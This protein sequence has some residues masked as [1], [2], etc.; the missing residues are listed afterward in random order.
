M[1]KGIA[2]AHS[3][4][5]IAAHMTSGDFVKGNTPP[6]LVPLM[7][8]CLLASLM[9]FI[10]L[11]LW[12]PC[13]FLTDDNLDGAFPFFVEVGSNLLA[14]HSPFYS[15]Y[16][17]GGHY[18]YLRDAGCF[19]WHPVYLLVSLLAGTPLRLCIL[20]IDSLFLFAVGTSGFVCLAHYLRRELL[21]SLSD[22]WIL[23]YCLS[24]NYSMIALTTAASWFHFEASYGALPWLTL[25][26]L[27]RQ[28]RRGLAYVAV[29]SVH[30]ILG[31]HLAPTLSNSIFLSLFALLLAARRRTAAPLLVWFGGTLIALT[32]ISP[33]L[34]PMTEGFLASTRNLGVGTGEM[35][36][37]NVSFSSLP[38]SVLA[39]MAVWLVHVPEK[40]YETYTLA[41]GA[42]AAA[43]CLIPAVLGR[44]KWRDIDVVTMA[45]LLILL[46]FIAR[47]HW[48]SLILVHLPIVRSMRW[49]FREFLQF[50][51]FLHLLLIVR[52]PGMKSITCRGLAVLGTALVVV[53]LFL[54]PVPPTFNEMDWD[55]RLLLSGKVYDYWDKVH[56]YLKPGDKVA[57][58]I[59]PEL[60]ASD[61]FEEPYS[62]LGTYNY[63]VLA[64]FDNISGYSSNTMPQDQ[65]Y[66]PGLPSYYP[67]GAYIPENRDRLRK[68]LP[69]LRFITL[70]SLHPLK[71]T[72]SSPDGSITDLTP[73]VPKELSPK[74]DDHSRGPRN[75]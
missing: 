62:L 51:F 45:M 8:K 44:F 38:S 70:E 9:V 30:E 59:P 35:E 66:M 33:L 55:R 53:P 47:P 68:L 22:G 74:S 17:F 23:F 13:F 14:G 21:L 6:P 31:G 73:F 32:V 4:Y 34:V 75:P 27:H 25:G 64:R 39:G 18:D 16:L 40:T 1:A 24:F 10:L 58:L 54:Y 26:I 63:A 52:P 48:L 5:S 2:G 43:W 3:T 37:N 50:T 71:I 72:L 57:V 12:R 56:R 46:V 69:K 42:S 61:R 28:W 15:T 7:R 19:M 60:Y 67:F 65:L 20:D 29:F 11:E 36:A 49:P 41:T